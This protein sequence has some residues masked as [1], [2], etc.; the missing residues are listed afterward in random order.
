MPA[1]QLINFVQRAILKA[2]VVFLEESSN[3]SMPVTVYHY[4]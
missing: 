1:T 4:C 3:F 2:V